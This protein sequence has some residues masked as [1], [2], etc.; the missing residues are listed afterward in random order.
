VNVG[1]D[2]SPGPGRFLFDTSL[3]GNHNSG[4]D[5]AGG[6]SDADREALIEYLKSL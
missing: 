1:F 2:T 3:D 5:W 6:L 4:H